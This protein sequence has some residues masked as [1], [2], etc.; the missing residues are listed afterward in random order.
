M[1]KVKSKYVTLEFLK[2]LS[3]DRKCTNSAELQ[4]ILPQRSLETEDTK[5]GHA[6]SGQQELFYLLCSMVQYLL[7]LTI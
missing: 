7:K 1:D 5:E 6:I 3:Q 2:L 4:L